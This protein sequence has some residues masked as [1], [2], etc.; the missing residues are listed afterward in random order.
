MGT[1][2]HEV[3][4]GSCRKRPLALPVPLDRVYNTSLC[5]IVVETALVEEKDEMLIEGDR[6]V[7]QAIGRFL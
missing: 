2:P 5:Q 3:R 7:Q 6:G 4:D 1:G